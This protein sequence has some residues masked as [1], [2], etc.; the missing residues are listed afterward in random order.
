MSESIE[1]SKNEFSDFLKWIADN[2]KKFFEKIKEIFGIESETK[3]KLNK[4]KDDLLANMVLTWENLDDKKLSDKE[5]SI[6]ENLVWKNNDF[7]NFI[8]WVNDCSDEVKANEFES[9]I[10]FIINSEKKI[11]SSKLQSLFEMCKNKYEICKKA[12]ENEKLK[13]KGK[14]DIV[15]YYNKYKDE[16]NWQNPN[17]ED[18]V[19]MFE[20][21]KSAKE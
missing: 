11:D 15:N 19:Q 7:K 1:T 6:I 17:V 2:I 21:D 5:K 13:W 3:E 9:V 16:H 20:E 8:E 10:K 4:L 14:D 12:S 18:L